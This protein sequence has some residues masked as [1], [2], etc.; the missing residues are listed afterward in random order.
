MR[1]S[2]HAWWQR[3]KLNY[4]SIFES[5]DPETVGVRTGQDTDSGAGAQQRLGAVLEETW[6]GLK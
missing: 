4:A 3:S 1:S 2:P 6:T 5:I